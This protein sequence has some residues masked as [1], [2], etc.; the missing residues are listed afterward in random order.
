MTGK[1][2]VIIVANI[3]AT[4]RND[5]ARDILVAAWRYQQL[6]LSP[7]IGPSLARFDF[8]TGL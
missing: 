5:L 7:N 6:A 3:A 1:P 8:S 2:E 4:C